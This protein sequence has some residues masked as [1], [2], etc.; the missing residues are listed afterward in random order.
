MTKSGESQTSLKNTQRDLVGRGQDDVAKQV[1]KLIEAKKREVTLG[2]A[3]FLIDP[4]LHLMSSNATVRFVVTDYYTA[5]SGHGEVLK[6][7]N[8]AV[9]VNYS[10]R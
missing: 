4:H 1:A 2:E 3:F 10:T 6:R 7:P 5:G 8:Q 9:V